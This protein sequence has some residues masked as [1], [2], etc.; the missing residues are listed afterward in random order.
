LPE[1]E[2]Y[3][4]GAPLKRNETIVNYSDMVVAIHDGSSRG[5]QYVIDYAAKVGK[6][7]KVHIVLIDQ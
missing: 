1:Y 4:R 5:T 6:P 7:C 2:K 3:K